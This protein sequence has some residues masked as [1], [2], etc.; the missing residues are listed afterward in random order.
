MLTKPII[1]E[2]SEIHPGE[3]SCTDLLKPKVAKAKRL[4]ERQKDIIEVY[5]RFQQ[6]HSL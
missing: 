1:I 4:T 6:K 5:K 3:R 2:I